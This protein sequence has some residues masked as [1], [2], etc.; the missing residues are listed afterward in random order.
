MP[1]GWFG[2]KRIGWGASPR[3]WQGWFVTAV[4][5]VAM[6]LT[7]FLA[8]WCAVRFGVPVR[9]LLVVAVPVEIA[10]FLL[11][12]WATYDRDAI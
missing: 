8:R 10:I 6:L 11:V 4:Y 7:T 2:P 5:L 1:K 9:T 3:S 12:V